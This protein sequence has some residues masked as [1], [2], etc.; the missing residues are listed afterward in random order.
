[1]YLRIAAAYTGTISVLFSKEKTD[2]LLDLYWLLE[3]S[4]E[5]QMRGDKSMP[6]CSKEIRNDYVSAFECDKM[7]VII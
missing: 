7:E 4:S 3:S 1:M 5:R 6:H 2:T